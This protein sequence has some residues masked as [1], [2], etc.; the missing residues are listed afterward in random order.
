MGDG[1]WLFFYSSCLGLPKLQEFR[2]AD[3]IKGCLMHGTGT[4][5]GGTALA[6]KVTTRTKEQHFTD[7]E[8]VRLQERHAREP[9]I[10]GAEVHATRIY[11]SAQRTASERP[12]IL[13]G[14]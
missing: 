2:N 1:L 6:L 8:A 5:D 11:H 9:C 10:V 13:P 7:P 12:A 4:R 3:R 14:V